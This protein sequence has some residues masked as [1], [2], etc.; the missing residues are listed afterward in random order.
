VQFNRSG[1]PL[2][3][4]PKVLSGSLQ[5]LRA[6]PLAADGKRL[7]GQGSVSFQLI[8][9]LSRSSEQPPFSTSLFDCAEDVIAF[10]AQAGPAEVQVSSGRARTTV[11]LDVV[12]AD[13]LGPVTFTEQM[14]RA[15]TFFG[16][17]DIPAIGVSG[18]IDG[19]PLWGVQCDWELS[20][21]GPNLWWDSG[22]RLGTD[23]VTLYGINGS[24]GTYDATCTIVGTHR[25]ETTRITLK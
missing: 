6:F 19:E 7:S 17:V 9:P 24:A 21:S 5:G 12:S 23:L 4:R 20:P 3:P 8:G 14:F 1:T 10:R 22:G 18:T 25:R 13:W 15:Q 2:P 16:P 11:S